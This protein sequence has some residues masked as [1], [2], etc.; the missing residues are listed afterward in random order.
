MGLCMLEGRRMLFNTVAA[1]HCHL[2]DVRR[3]MT[4]TFLSTCTELDEI[5]SAVHRALE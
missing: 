2:P 4:A 1:N 3:S 5:L